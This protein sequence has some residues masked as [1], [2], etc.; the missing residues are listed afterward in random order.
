M[1]LNQ[2]TFSFATDIHGNIQ[3]LESFLHESKTRRS[4]YT[5]IGG[6]IAPKKGFVQ[7]KGSKALLIDNTKRELPAKEA[8]RTG[9]FRIGKEDMTSEEYSTFISLFNKLCLDYGINGYGST[10]DNERKH[11]VY[12]VE[13][14][15]FLDK[16]FKKMFS[17]FMKNNEIASYCV[18]H[19]VLN[20]GQIFWNWHDHVWNLFRKEKIFKTIHQRQFSA[21]QAQQLARIFYPNLKDPY[22]KIRNYSVEHSVSLEKIMRSFLQS[23]YPANKYE[24]SPKN[25]ISIEAQKAALE[26][27][28][29]EIAKYQTQTQSSVI[30]IL[31]NDDCPELK[32]AMR[33][34]ESAGVIT[35]LDSEVKRISD[36][37]QVLGY[38][39]IPEIPGT[40]DWWHTDEETIKDDLQ[41]MR[42]DPSI[43]HTVFHIHVPPAGIGLSQAKIP[44]SAPA[45]DWGSQSVATYVQQ[46]QPELVLSGHLHESW[47]ITGQTH[48]SIG[49]SFVINP[50]ACEYTSRFV[51]GNLNEPEKYA[52]TGST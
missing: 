9:Y 25:D 44:L 50:G 6:D 17:D 46:T 28:L 21:E 2:D 39:Y 27:I 18:K 36:S 51:F 42:P 16:F 5:F 49:K 7:L 24:L 37:L 33:T 8:V 22:Q 48:G 12:T 14:I 41:K 47:R 31:G 34:A 38:S 20:T 4:E 10:T 13:E 43:A 3:N 40:V 1:R 15:F 52:L 30:M 26:K 29:C 19:I 45:A 11:P 35:Y 32:T 23:I